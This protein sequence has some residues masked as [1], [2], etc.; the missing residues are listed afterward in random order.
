MA[1]TKNLC[2]VCGT[3]EMKERELGNKIGLMCTECL[4]LDI[5][6]IRDKD[7]DKDTKEDKQEKL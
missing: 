3:G 7:T 2:L 6:S 1:D 4:Y 5:K